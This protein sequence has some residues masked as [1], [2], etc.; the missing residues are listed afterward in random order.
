MDY[1]M[2]DGLRSRGTRWIPYEDVSILRHDGTLVPLLDLH[3]EEWLCQMHFDSV[4]A[5]QGYAW[6]NGTKD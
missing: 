4:F 3:S 5:E 2:Y 1:V 6:L